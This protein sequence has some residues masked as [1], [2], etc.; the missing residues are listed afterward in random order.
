MYFRPFLQPH[1][2]FL[3][4]DVTCGRYHF[5]EKLTSSLKPFA[6]N[7]VLPEG[8]GGFSKAKVVATTL[9][10]FMASMDRTITVRHV[11]NYR[12]NKRGDREEIRE[13]EKSVLK[14]SICTIYS[15]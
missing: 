3:L 9:N 12:L 13:K 2:F 14:L 1:P 4:C 5:R 10:A 8:R 15:V 11:P 6:L 7:S